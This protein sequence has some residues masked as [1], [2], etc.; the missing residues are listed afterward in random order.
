[1][2]KT[3]LIKEIYVHACLSAP[4]GFSYKHKR[5]NQMFGVKNLTEDYYCV[6][7]NKRFIPPLQGT[8]LFCYLI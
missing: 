6:S 7:Q 8:K 5:V 3:H 4:C 1:M 2:Q